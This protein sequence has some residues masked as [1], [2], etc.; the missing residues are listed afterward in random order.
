[1]TAYFFCFK[2][3]NICKFCCLFYYINTLKKEV[4]FLTNWSDERESQKLL[5]VYAWQLFLW[6]FLYL[7]V[8]VCAYQNPTDSVL[9]TEKQRRR[10][11]RRKKKCQKKI[12]ITEKVLQ[13]KH[14]CKKE[15]KQKSFAK[16]F[17]IKPSTITRICN[18]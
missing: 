6:I 12:E 18:M 10:R 8:S 2:L 4:N 3:I 7:C 11:R 9:V 14:I 15:A 1:M 13:K 5:S 16:T 17:L